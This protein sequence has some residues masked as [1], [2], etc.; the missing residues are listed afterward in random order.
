MPPK[1]QP[2]NKY[3]F[4]SANQFDSAMLDSV[5]TSD[6]AY[7]SHIIQIITDTSD[8]LMSDM[9]VD[10]STNDNSNILIIADDTITVD[11]MLSSSNKIK[12]SSRYFR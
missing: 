4:E 8:F 6:L 2:K 12:I 5:M 3:V 1:V 10:D 9:I 11:E 7:V